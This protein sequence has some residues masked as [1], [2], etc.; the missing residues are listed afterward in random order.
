MIKTSIQPWYQGKIR[1][2]SIIGVIVT[3]AA[4][5]E[6]NTKQKTV[7]TAIIPQGDLAMQIYKRES[8]GCCGGWV[9]HMNTSGFQTN[10]HN[11][12]DLDPV[13]EK[14]N[15]DSKYQSCHTGVQ[16][17]FVFEGHVPANAVKKF[18]AAKPEGAIGLSVPGMPVGSPGMEMGERYD[19]YDVLLLK[20]DGTSEV[21]LTVT[22]P[23]K[24]V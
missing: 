21:Y 19:T 22:G 5:S 14:F 18:L 1:L 7:E 23:A 17:G 20:K 16:E 24:E 10:V 6:A 13:K 9:D 3:L 2:F 12:E 15:I 11:L 8:C 4:C